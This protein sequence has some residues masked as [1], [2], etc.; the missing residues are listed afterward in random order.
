M[1][2]PLLAGATTSTVP[3][4]ARTQL[5]AAEIMET[6]RR[7]VREARDYEPALPGYLPPALY[8]EAKRQGYDLAGYAPTPH[9]PIRYREPMDL[10]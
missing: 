9:M 5:T 10:R 2:S 8:A 3:D 4:P 1:R 6:M 7:M